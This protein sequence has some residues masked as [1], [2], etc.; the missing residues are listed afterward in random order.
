MKPSLLAFV[1]FCLTI[2]TGCETYDAAAV[3]DAVGHGLDGYSV[4]SGYG[5]V[6]DDQHYNDSGT[7][8]SSYANPSY[9]SSSYSTQP[10]ADHTDASHHQDASSEPDDTKDTES[11]DAAAKYRSEIN[12]I[13]DDGD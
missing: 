3:A 5:H 2:L 7:T 1:L 11:S 12:E 9:G 4:G 8:T 6:Y 13:A 10:A